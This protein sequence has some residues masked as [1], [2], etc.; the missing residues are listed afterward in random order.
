MIW[1]ENLSFP[2]ISAHRLQS[3]DSFT[4]KMKKMKK[5]NNLKSN[6]HNETTMVNNELQML[7]KEQ[8]SAAE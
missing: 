5:K 3:K 1:E 8:P 7:Q 4:L 2:V 6:L